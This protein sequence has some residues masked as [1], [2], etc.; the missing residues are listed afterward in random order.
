MR[1]SECGVGVMQTWRTA[2][3]VSSKVQAGRVLEAHSEREAERVRE[4]ERE[5]EREL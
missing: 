4:T 2:V 3:Y 1:V 5:R